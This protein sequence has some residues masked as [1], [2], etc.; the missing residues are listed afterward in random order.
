MRSSFKQSAILS[1][2]VFIGLCMPI[3]AESLQSMA[4][5]RWH[6]WRKNQQVFP[7]AAW[8]YFSKFDGTVEEYKMYAGANLTMVSPPD[9]QV[10]NALS[11]GLNVLLGGWQRLHED[12]AKLEK[13]MTFPTPNHPKVIGYQ[14]K[15]EPEPV[16]FEGLGEAMRMVYTQDNRKTIPIVDLLPNWAW[17]R[18]TR[19]DQRYGLNYDHFVRRFIEVSAPPVLLNCHYPTLLDGTD[20]PE[21]YAN[22]ETFRKHALLNDIGLMGF[23]LNVDFSNQLRRPSDSDLRWMVY[24]ALAYGAQGIWYWNYRI[25]PTEIFNEGLVTYASGEPTPE[26]YLVRDLNAELLALGPVLLKLKSNNVYHTGSD[27]PSGATRFPHE[28]DTGASVFERFEGDDFLIGEFFNQDDAADDT[29]YCLLVN[30]KHGADLSSGDASLQ[31]TCVFRPAEYYP[32]AYQYDPE[33]GTM[34]ALAPCIHQGQSAWITLSVPGGQGYLVRL[35]KKPLRGEASTPERETI[36]AWFARRA[37]VVDGLLNDAYWKLTNSYSLMTIQ[38]AAGSQSEPAENSTAW[39]TWRDGHL[40]IAARLEDSDILAEGQTDDEPHYKLGDTLEVFLKPAY[41]DWYW[42]IWL[43]PH[44]KKTSL[45]WIEKGKQGPDHG[46]P[47]QLDITYES[48]IDGTLNDSADRDT[49]WTCEVRIPF[50]DLSQG[51]DLFARGPWTILVARQNYT[52]R[53]DK[54]HRELSAVPR[55]S[56]GSFHLVDEYAQLDMILK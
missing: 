51:G 52:G 2:A 27:I 46:K 55:L 20:T 1:A 6:A 18:N 23:V 36:T 8:A 16:L 30:K 45:F 49:G 43:T 7:I 38:D 9:D 33:N 4:S 42:E 28:G 25:Q 3:F 54:D 47:Y 14:F 22:Y 19:R 48:V 32:F 53:V 21:Y 15:D 24:T 12:P 26:Y 29:A 40:T 41:S 10:N 34:H 13:L 11:A 50:E 5:E 56:R 44:G 35:S 37:V 39:V 31:N 17:Q